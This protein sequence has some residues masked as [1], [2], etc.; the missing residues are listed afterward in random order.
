MYSS[1]KA[2]AIAIVSAWNNQRIKIAMGQAFKFIHLE[3]KCWSFMTPQ[4]SSLVLLKE[5]DIR[6]LLVFLA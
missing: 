1:L 5:R 2:G 6:K 3:V 4:H